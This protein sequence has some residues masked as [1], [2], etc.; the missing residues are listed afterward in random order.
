MT[1]TFV[2]HLDSVKMNQG[3]RHDVSTSKVK[4][5]KLLF[6]PTFRHTDAAL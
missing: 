5:Q 6:S 1:L 3:A 4:G 2:F